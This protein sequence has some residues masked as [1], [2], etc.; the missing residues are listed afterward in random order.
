[1]V[2]VNDIDFFYVIVLMKV[3][4]VSFTYHSRVFPAKLHSN[5]I[6]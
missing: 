2:S 4:T 6:S 5:T 3:L 1:M